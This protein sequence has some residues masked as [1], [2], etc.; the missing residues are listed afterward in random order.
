MTHAG[1]QTPAR[2]GDDPPQVVVLTGVP[3]TG[4]TTRCRELAAEASA[5]GLLVRGLTAAI[6]P[7]PCGMERWAEDLGSG[8][9]RLLARAAPDADVAAGQ[10]RWRL[11][12]DA[13]AWADTVLRDAC[14]ADLLIVDE[15]GPVELLH[16]R[17]TLAGVRQALAGSYGLAVVVVRP[18][19]V[20]RFLELFA[21]LSAEVVDVERIEL[22]H[23]HLE[24]L[25]ARHRREASE[26]DG[27]DGEGGAAVAPLTSEEARL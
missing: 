1:K 27:A 4:K 22:L 12:D 26:R 3:G 9:R 7:G 6:E 25:I 14:P 5:R 16:R 8:R 19:L 21:P 11:R 15:V 20:P 2:G 10:P 13:L 24:R 18:W 23:G 17:G